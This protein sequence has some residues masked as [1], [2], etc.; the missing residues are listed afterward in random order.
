MKIVADA[1][2]PYV[3]ECF[4]SIGEVTAMSG[5]EM[6][7][8]IVADADILLVRSITP[9]G[10]DL[11]AGSKV[12]FVATATIGFDHIDLDFLRQNKIGFA[13]APGSNANSAAEYIIAG[14]LKIGQRHHIELEG[15]SIGV[16]GVGNV[17]T[18]VVAKAEALGMT[19]VRN[20]PPKLD[21]TGDPKFRP[22]DEALACDVVTLHVPLTT[23]GPYPTAGMVDESFL[24]RIKPGAI[25]INTSR[26]P[27]VSDAALSA[28]LSA[29]HIDA[30]VL[31]V[32]QG[33]PAIDL[34][35]LRLVEIATPHIAGYSYDGKVRATLMLYRSLCE[36]LGCRPKWNP[37]P[38]MPPPPNPCITP[39]AK[40]G[41]TAVMQA[42]TCAY[43]ILFDNRNL[44]EEL[45]MRPDLA[46]IHFDGLRKYYRARRE[47]PCFTVRCVWN[48]NLAQSVAALGFKTE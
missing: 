41:Q 45:S 31:D 30:A 32:W 8:W 2:I 7:P 13:S 48:G 17:G 5:R 26:G 15:T 27:V 4:S 1:N 22:V 40:G 36:H 3:R 11:L 14:L 16:I 46:A 37:D 10:V 9:V 42:A 6:T 25:F 34:D 23:E 24:E 29:K 35:L 47:F 20:D 43:D 33:E 12:R 44:R 19:V 28:A 18:R 38:A 39:A 21:A